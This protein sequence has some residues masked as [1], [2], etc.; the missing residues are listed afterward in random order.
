[1]PVA[2]KMRHMT[3]VKIADK[4]GKAKSFL[5]S[6][7]TAKKIMTLVS[8]EEGSVLYEDAFPRMKDRAK[9]QASVIRGF[10][11]RDGLTQEELA[12]KIKITQGDLSKVEAGKRRV[13]RRIAERLAEVF[14]SDWRVFL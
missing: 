9:R 2:E 4:K 8:A 6:D 11:E 3:E 1:M 5:V 13:G 14:K 10:R 12:E 7:A